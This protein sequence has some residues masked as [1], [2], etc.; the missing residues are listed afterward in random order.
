VEKIFRNCNLFAGIR[1]DTET[2]IRT[3]QHVFKF[4]ESNDILPLFQ[5]NDKSYIRVHMKNKEIESSFL[6]SKFFDGGVEFTNPFIG[7]GIHAEYS[8][9]TT[10]TDTQKEILTINC[11]RNHL[12]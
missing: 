5:V 10:R 7:I 4:K 12:N 8:K 3:F 2:P 1:M 11:K 9:I 6:S